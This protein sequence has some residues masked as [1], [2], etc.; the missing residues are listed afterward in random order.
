MTDKIIEYD[1]NDDIDDVQESPIIKSFN[2]IDS[3]QKRNQQINELNKDILAVKDMMIELNTMI[4][5]QDENI[6]HLEENIINTNNICSKAN[7]ELLLAE[8]YQKSYFSK[9]IYTPLILGTTI[10]ILF[11]ILKK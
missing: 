8:D 2:H 7:D 9:A 6:N 3:I 11:G 1:F 5:N 4:N 10:F